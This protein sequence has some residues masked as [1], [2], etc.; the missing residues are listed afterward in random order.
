MRVRTLVLALCAAL[1]AMPAFAQEQSGAIQGVIKDSSG[2]VMP[3]VT[4]EARNATGG[5]S[6]A[7][8]NGEGVYRFPALPP[9]TY[10]VTANL[11]GFIPASSENAVLVLGK[12]LSIDLTLQP[13]GVTETVQVRAES[14]LID[15]KQNAAYATIQADTISRIPKGRDFQSILRQAPGAQDESKAGGIQIDGASGAENRWVIDGMDTTN[16]R[17][18]VSGKTMLLDFVQ[19]VQVKSSGYNAEFGGATGGV[20]SVITKSGTNAMH[21]QAGTY[22]T[23]NQF[24]GD[25]RTF[26]RFNPFNTRVPESGLV[27]PDDHYRYWSPLGDLG[28]PVF[29]DK[30]WYYAGFGYTKNNYERTA[31]FYTDPAKT[32]RDFKWWSDAKYFN[33]NVTA[34]LTNNMRV[35]F[36][37]SNQRN[38][39]RGTAPGLE[40]DNALPLPA[41]A[42]YPGGVPSRGMTRSA[43]DKNADGSINQTAYNNRWVR[44]G[45]N[46]TNDTYSGN[47][48]WVIKPTFFVNVQG[49]S[50][51]FNDNFTPPEFRGNDI[52]HYFDAGN[53]NEYM[54]AQGFPTVPAQ[55][56]QPSGYSDVI[57]SFGTDHDL[58]TRYFFNANST[59]FVTAGG[60]HTFK[61]GMRAERF[62][63]DVLRGN[64]KP[65][66]SLDWGSTYTTGT[67]E[68]VAGKYG[69]YIVN[70]TGTIGKV[71]SNNYS[72]W[73]QD[74]WDLS[75]RLTINAGVRTENEHVPS[76]KDKAQFPDALDIKFGFKDK[77][78]P[79]LG[80][81]YDVKGDGKWKTYGSYGWFYDI[82]KLELPRGSFGGDHWVNYVWTLD[83][84]DWTKISCGEGTTGCPGRFIESIDYR[85]SSNQVDSLFEEY[86]NRPGMTGIDPNLKPVKTGEFTLGADHELSPR[87]ALGLRYVHKWMFRTIEDTGIWYKGTEDYLIANPGYGLA[88]VMEPQYPTFVTPKPVRKYDGVELTLTKRWSDNWTARLSYLYSR[89]WGNYSGLASGD[90]NGRVS[91]N[92]NRYYDNT[93]M[94]Y[95]SDGKPVY[96]LLPTDRP[97]TLKASGAYTFKTGTTAGLNWF[98]ETG[99][100]QTAVLRFTGYPAFP[101]GRGNMGRSPTLSQLDLNIMQEVKLIGHSKIQVAANIDNVFDQKTWLSYYYPNLYGPTPYVSSQAFGGNISLAMPPAVLYQPGGYNVDQIIA[102][103]RARGGNLL[104]NPLYKAHGTFQGRRDIR[105]DARI[106]F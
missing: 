11:D 62:G 79:R 72:L 52:R 54:L 25:R 70:Q 35:K 97:H 46:S 68:T 31:T 18:G 9:G 63:N 103:Y 93:L 94:S 36:A 83:D 26:N 77:I 90:E 2:A 69:Y 19:E 47:F 29:K 17:T 28:G 74:S 45:G 13:K 33:Y 1:L 88:V 91:P 75:P 65:V 73:V 89:L 12:M 86:F 27:N 96:G 92:V 8:T 67:G 57:S 15:V 39:N 23:G 98:I 95:G 37:G 34:Q 43:F 71:H 50:Y 49:G 21:G 102:N 48:D 66:I 61:V 30:L 64:V 44:Q 3:G 41:N 82:T 22:Y 81:A 80:F 76:Y 51:R 104:D 32:P 4:V 105:I 78:A 24:W 14:P 106:T 58:Y 55:L 42:Y 40:P 99:T 20:V 60:Q 87:T 85:H 84:P 59:F 100:P 5:V 38:G 53:G 56:Q 101:W 10:T 6:T 7:V 16:L